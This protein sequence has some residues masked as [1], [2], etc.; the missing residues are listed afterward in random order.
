VTVRVVPLVVQAGGVETPSPLSPAISSGPPM[1]RADAATDA[2]GWT[3]MSLPGLAE[4]AY[5]LEVLI[6]GALV[7]PRPTLVVGTP[8]VPPGPALSFAGVTP[9]PLKA[10][11]RGVVRFT[12]PASAHVLLDLYDPR[13]RKVRALAN[14][15][16][17]AGPNEV[18]LWTSDAQGRALGAGVYFLRLASVAGAVFE[19]R[20]ARVVVL[21]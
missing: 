5:R 2:D 8:A 10:G 3:S 20:V 6:R 11:V 9:S 16:F 21:P 4:G 15:R 1:A 13:G 12:L 18:A 19:P 17:A 14:E 7:R